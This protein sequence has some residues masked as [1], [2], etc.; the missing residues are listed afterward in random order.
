MAQQVQPQAEVREMRFCVH[1]LAARDELLLKSL[2][3]LLS[4]RTHQRW[5]YSPEGAVDLVVLGDSLQEVSS[6]YTQRIAS[7]AQPGTSALALT[8][9]HAP[10]G[11]AHFLY[12][13]LHASALEQMLNQLGRL[14]A[15]SQPAPKPVVNAVAAP[16]F[17]AGD[18]FRL[19]RWPPTALL[20]TALHRK[21]AT[22]M[23]GKAQSLEV[24][25]QRSGAD[26]AACEQFLK[27]L[28]RLQ[29]LEV[30]SPAAEFVPAFDNPLTPEK[31]A[32]ESPVNWKASMGLVARI[33]SRLGL[34][35]TASRL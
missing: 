29:L 17:S 33:R 23:A 34:P 30:T 7:L 3:R 24:L 14:I 13:P 32:H 8:I 12:L 15:T 10:Q 28:H 2:I 5:V 6:A 20:A 1:Q 25:Q 18:T 35:S 22:L 9:G 16:H 11:Q 4:H 26:G 31:P 27:D 21:L 19:L